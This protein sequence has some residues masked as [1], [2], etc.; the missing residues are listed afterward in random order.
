MGKIFWRDSTNRCDYNAL[1]SFSDMCE[2]EVRD[3]IKDL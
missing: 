2:K 3:K 1:L